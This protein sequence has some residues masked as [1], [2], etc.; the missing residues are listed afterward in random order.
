MVV[1]IFVNPTQ[2]G[3]KEKDLGH[4]IP[5]LRNKI[6]TFA[7]V[8]AWTWFLFPNKQKSIRRDFKR[9]SD[10]KKSSKAW[11]ESRGLGPLSGAWPPWS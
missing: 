3:P 10:Y 11:K 5:G 6:W 7:S 4:A 9:V 8:K 2:F 1:T